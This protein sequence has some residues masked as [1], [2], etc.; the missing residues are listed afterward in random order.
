MVC[1]DGFARRSAFEREAPPSA[2]CGASFSGTIAV[3]LNAAANSTT[4]FGIF[5]AEAVPEPASALVF[6]L[7]VAAPGAVR[8][9]GETV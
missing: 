6:G 2:S 1:P 7:G 3:T 8:R 4:S 5:I 9:R